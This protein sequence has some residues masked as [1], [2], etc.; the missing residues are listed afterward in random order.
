[1]SEQENITLA[2]MISETVGA[3]C[4]QNG[5][6][7]PNGFV[8]CVSRIAEDG[9]QVLTLGSGE[10]QPT[11]ISLGLSSYL[12]RN[13]EMDVDFE[14]TSFVTAMHDCDEDEE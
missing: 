5:F 7:I 3:Y 8:Y 4:A 11:H 2:E 1:M 6:G 13:F 12:K 9:E 14:L 10:S